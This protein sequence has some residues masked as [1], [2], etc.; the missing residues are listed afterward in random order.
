MQF[1]VYI[2]HLRKKETALVEQ[3]QHKLSSAQ[4]TTMSRIQR[5]GRTGRAEILAP[6]QMLLESNVLLELQRLAIIGLVV[7]SQV[8]QNARHSTFTWVRGRSS[9]WNT[10]PLEVFLLLCG[11]CG[12]MGYAGTPAPTELPGAWS[13]YSPSKVCLLLADI[14]VLLLVGVGWLMGFLWLCWLY[15]GA[16]FWCQATELKCLHFYY[17]YMWVCM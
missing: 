5:W 4:Q 8:N 10:Q 11:S 2:V 13:F 9:Q 6:Q 7:L 15:T 12:K 16:W 14:L 3:R 1:I 17:N